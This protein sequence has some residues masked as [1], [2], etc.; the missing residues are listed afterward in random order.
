MANQGWVNAPAVQQ[1]AGTSFGTYTTAKTVIPATA[2]HTID[3][4][5]LRIGTAFEILVRGGIG[6]LVTTPGTITFQVMLG[7]I[8][9]FTTGGIQL[10]ATAH[11]NLPFCLDILLTCRAIGSGTSANFMGQARV[12]G[13]MFTKTAGQ[14]DGVNS[15]SVIV[16]PQTAP[17]VGTGFDSTVDNI[18]D[19][20]TAFS[21]S[22]AANTIKIEQCV[23]KQLN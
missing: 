12:S 13:V 18:L 2:L 22:D 10:N 9:V 17:A 3:A 19:F 5:V 8:V 1:S 14:T 23:V 7:S 16:V 15:G 21:I 11:T 4:N 6:N 20:W